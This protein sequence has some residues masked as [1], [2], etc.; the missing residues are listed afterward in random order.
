MK[1][2]LIFAFLILSVSAN[3]QTLDSLLARFRRTNNTTIT[4]KTGSG[5]IT[6][7]NVGG[8]I[9]STLKYVQAVYDS[10]LAAP[11]AP[12]LQNVL[13]SGD[14]ANHVLTIYNASGLQTK[15]NMSAAAITYKDR[16]TGHPLVGLS[17]TGAKIGGLVLYDSSTSFTTSFNSGILSANRVLKSP[18]AGGFVAIAPTSS[19]LITLDNVL[20]NSAN[21]N[22]AINIGKKK[23]LTPY[24][25]SIYISPLDSSF[26]MYGQD[27]SASTQFFVNTSTSNIEL[28]LQD[29]S[30]GVSF[31]FSE[32]A[33]LV[34]TGTNIGVTVNTARILSG[35]GSPEAAITAPVGSL[36]LRTDGGA[37]TTLYVK[38]SGAGNTGWVGK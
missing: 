13:N 1:R 9:D 24:V 5:S 14:S 34:V 6:P 7:I 10:L 20:T 8:N 17:R 29:I 35:S 23:S 11:S 12:T 4:T 22:Q 30:T 21:T 36:W 38:E 28:S 37:G 26:A 32:G 3:A 2:L 25:N 27:T 15:V 18:D 19:G 31:D 33:G 16:A